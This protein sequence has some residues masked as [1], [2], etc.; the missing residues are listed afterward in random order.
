LTERLAELL[1]R[2]EYL[3]AGNDSDQLQAALGELLVNKMYLEW[4]LADIEG[5]NIDGIPAEPRGLV[6]DGPEQLVD[7]IVLA[8]KKESNLSSDEAKNY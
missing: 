4:G 7:E 2:Q 5:L 6:E 3:A 1:N 8:I